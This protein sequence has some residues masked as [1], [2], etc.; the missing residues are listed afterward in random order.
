[1][2]PKATPAETDYR[3]VREWEDGPEPTTGIAAGCLT[4]HKT[5]LMDAIAEALRD[6]ENSGY[7][8]GTAARHEETE[9]RLQSLE[10]KEE[11]RREVDAGQDW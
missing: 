5:L 10:R 4:P 3:L 9:H 1:M 2:T 7:E 6:A 11:Y 8:R